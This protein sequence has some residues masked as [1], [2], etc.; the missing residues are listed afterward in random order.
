MGTAQ[1]NVRTA[2]TTIGVSEA[3]RAKL[4]KDLPAQ[5]VPAQGMTSSRRASTTPCRP[6]CAP[7]APSAPPPTTR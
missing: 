7:P 1:A 5:H 3:N 2:Q 6:T 4:Q